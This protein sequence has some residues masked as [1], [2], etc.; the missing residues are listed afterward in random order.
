[1]A[2]TDAVIADVLLAAVTGC[3]CAI[4]PVDAVMLLVL[5]EAVTSWVV[6]PLASTSSCHPCGVARLSVPVSS[7]QP[8][9]VARFKAIDY[10]RMVGST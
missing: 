6:P 9:G 10:T 2:A 7:I 3:D 1:M 8:D 4:A 5:L